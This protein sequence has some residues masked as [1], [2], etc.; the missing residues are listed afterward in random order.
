MATLAI[1]IEHSADFRLCGE[2]GQGMDMIR[3]AMMALALGAAMAGAAACSPGGATE[4]AAEKVSEN[5]YVTKQFG[6]TAAA[7]EGWYVMDSEVTEK[8]MDLGKEITTADFDSRTKAAMESSMNRT[9]NIFGFLKYA[10]G[11]PRD[12]GA[13]I[14]A[15]AEDVSIAPGIERGSDYFFHMRKLLEQPG[16]NTQIN[17]DYT[18]VDIGGHSFDRMDV[19]MTTMGVPVQQ[20][21][22][23]ARHGKHV[24][25]FIQSY[26]TDEDLATLDGVLKSVKLDW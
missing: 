22:F 7:P 14:M 8:L 2:S 26:V 18:T 13:A 16:S 11:A 4:V 20:R 3:S 25:A 15:L 9:T 19:T 23:A 5:T 6:M 12:D 17:G 24:I 10:P 1:S 21:Y